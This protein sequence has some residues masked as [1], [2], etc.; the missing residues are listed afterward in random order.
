M[1][2]LIVFV[3]N[4]ILSVCSFVMNTVSK[5]P[6]SVKVMHVSIAEDTKKKVS[7]SRRYPWAKDDPSGDGD[8]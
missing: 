7:R 5:R 8:D 3:W 6:I 2:K 1:P 4:R